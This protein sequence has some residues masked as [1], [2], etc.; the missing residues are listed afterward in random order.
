[1]LEITPTQG[2][3]G[4]MRKFIGGLVMVLC[5]GV[6]VFGADV[7]EWIAQLK[8]AD[9][10]TRRAA[11]KA[12][13]EAGGDAKAA[14]PA[15][16]K[17]LKDKDMFVRRFSAIA[18]GEIGAD[19]QVALPGLKAALDDPRKEVQQAAA[20][21]LGK[22]GKGAVAALITVVK[23]ANRE[24]EVRRKA[25]EALG[26]L[27]A[28]ARSAVPTL[29]DGLKMVA[30]GNDK[31]KKKGP[32]LNDIRSEVAI[33]LG[34]I[35]AADDKGAIEALQALTDRRQRDRTLQKAAREALQKI[36]S[37]N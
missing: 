28:E 34:N 23:D 9:A 25:V 24:T 29:I 15:L 7:E 5:I 6:S 11:A 8:D 36:Q 27:G 2:S 12:L 33:A 10:E 21:A 20:S 3:E 13:A 16:V 35:A 14:A 32:N 30:P 18:L 17:A 4:I 37:N 19:P 31:N 26:T 1:M 22:M